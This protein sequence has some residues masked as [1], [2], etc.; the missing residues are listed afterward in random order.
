[1]DSV[2]R[3]YQFR[4]RRHCVSSRWSGGGPIIW[5]IARTCEIARSHG[6]NVGVMDTGQG[7]A[8]VDGTYS[9]SLPEHENIVGILI[10]L[11]LGRAGQ[12]SWDRSWSIVSDSLASP[13]ALAVFKPLTY[14]WRFKVPRLCTFW[15]INW[16]SPWLNTSIKYIYCRSL[17][18]QR[19]A[20]CSY[21]RQVYM[22][23]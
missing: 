18:R 3:T 19:R 4:M 8:S 23:Y 7:Y 9:S 12:P 21:R 6:T 2:G 13:S 16:K 20:R 11:H 1:M 22:G 15:T 10:Q 5:N 17:D 14:K